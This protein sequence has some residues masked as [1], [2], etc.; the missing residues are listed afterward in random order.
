MKPAKC[1]Y[2]NKYD[3]NAEFKF[4]AVLYHKIDSSLGIGLL[5]LKRTTKY[6]EKQ[7]VV[8]RCQNC[9]QEHHQVNKPAFFTGLIVAIISGI[10]IHLFALRYYISIPSGLG[11][12][13]LSALIY[14]GTV[15]R[16]RINSL[17][18]KDAN[19]FFE[20]PDIKNL[21]ENG[22]TIWKP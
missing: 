6:Y 5:G 15:Y 18:I 3:S 8:P 16:K 21:T 10:T 9:F 12:G 22:W 4:N 20:Y 7:I 13:F 2:C 19:D 14:I 17:G 11:F 1:F